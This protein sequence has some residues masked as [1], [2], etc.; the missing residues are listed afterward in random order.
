G[1]GL[2][3]FVRRCALWG[4]SQLAPYTT[5]LYLLQ[6]HA[7]DGDFTDVVALAEHAKVLL[8]PT[9]TS[10]DR[11]LFQNLLGLVALF[12][13]DAK[14]ARPAFDAAMASDPTN[15]VPFLNAAFTDL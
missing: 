4:A 10:A 8:P 3:A 7:P 13:N 9:P 2:I 11:S 14:A 5:A 1:E 12:K 6:K 15:P